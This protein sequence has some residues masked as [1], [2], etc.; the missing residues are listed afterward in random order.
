MEVWPR[1]D[2]FGACMHLWN[3]WSGNGGGSGNNIEN[4]EFSN[5]NCNVVVI[6]VV[7]KLVVIVEVG[8]MMMEVVVE[9]SQG[10]CS[11]MKTNDNNAGLTSGLR[12]KC[13]VY[14]ENKR[15]STLDK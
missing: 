2:L 8:K 12:W 6:V 13:S 9:L 3:V 7:I 1:S 14:Y 11:S 15:L 10:V 4:F 5:G